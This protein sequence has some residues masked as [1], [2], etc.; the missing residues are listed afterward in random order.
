VAIG[1]HAFLHGA[2]NSHFK[3]RS[4]FFI[5]L[6]SVHRVLNPSPQNYALYAH[7]NDKKDGRRRPLTDM[8]QPRLYNGLPL[9][10][11]DVDQSLPA[12]N[13]VVFTVLL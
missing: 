7:D 2:A 3:N 9:L 5:I 11:L 6:K 1:Y 12:N 8:F 4:S 10:D 13:L